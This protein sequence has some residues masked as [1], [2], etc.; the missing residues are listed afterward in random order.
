MVLAIEIEWPDAMLSRY[1]ADESREAQ[2]HQQLL[3]HPPF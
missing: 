1:D 3:L 2:Q